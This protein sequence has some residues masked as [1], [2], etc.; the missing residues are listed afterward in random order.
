METIKLNTGEIFE[1]PSW[2][3]ETNSTAEDHYCQWFLQ[4]LVTGQDE[5][6]RLVLEGFDPSSSQCIEVYAEEFGLQPHEVDVEVVKQCMFAHF[7]MDG[8][9]FVMVYL[10]PVK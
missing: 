1:V 8:D 5:H 4:E 10:K 7:G 9:D 2:I 6:D 3:S